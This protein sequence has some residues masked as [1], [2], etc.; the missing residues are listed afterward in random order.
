MGFL[1]EALSRAPHGI[2]QT[3]PML[4]VEERVEVIVR[5]E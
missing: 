4:V 3:V 1:S 2:A 5:V